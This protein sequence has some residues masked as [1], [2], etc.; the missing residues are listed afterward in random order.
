MSCLATPTQA[1][2]NLGN[3]PLLTSW[4]K[5]CITLALEH[6]PCVLGLVH[7]LDLAGVA[8]SVVDHEAAAHN[9]LAELLA[10]Y[11]ACAHFLVEGVAFEKKVY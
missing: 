1:R 10:S 3:L 9:L 6:G 8:V 11:Q 5:V 2:N 4:Q 7:E